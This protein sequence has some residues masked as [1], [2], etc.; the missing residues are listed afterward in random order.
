M[1]FHYFAL[2]YTI[3]F[4]KCELRHIHTSVF[5]RPSYMYV[6]DNDIYKESQLF[7]VF[8]HNSQSMRC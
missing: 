1:Y 3:E 2:I 4:Q 6:H 5:L 8:T 7:K